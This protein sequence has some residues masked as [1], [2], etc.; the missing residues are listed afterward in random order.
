MGLRQRVWGRLGRHLYS[1]FCIAVAACQVEPW[2]HGSVTAVWKPRG[3]MILGCLLLGNSPDVRRSEA[4]QPFKLLADSSKGSWVNAGVVG[5][6]LRRCHGTESI[7]VGVSLGF[8]QNL[9]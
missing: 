7:V 3:G 8:A 6:E 2:P 5:K 9:A 4:L 1:C